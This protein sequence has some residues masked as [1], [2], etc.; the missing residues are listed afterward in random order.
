MNQL[1]ENLWVRSYPLAVLGT[2]H[3]RNVSI[4]RVASGRLVVHSMAK[5]SPS[6]IAEISALGDPGWLVEAML[7]HDTYAR[8]G[9]EAFAGVPFLGPPG[10]AEVVGFPVQPLR[11]APP[12]WADEITVME[13]A[14]APK[15][16]EHVLLHKPS[17]SLIVADLIFNFAPEERGWNRF[18]HRYLAGFKRYPGMSRVFRFFIQDRLA[19]RAS[20]QKVL[21]ADFDRIIVGHGRVIDSQGKELLRRALADSHLLPEE[22]ASPNG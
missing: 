17:R 21:A 5:F 18:F 13:I 1:A 20:L 16:R 12:E 22:A 15:L 10:F 14:G 8:E 3:G 4:I 11:P 19:F 6:D 9:R 2:D 7:L